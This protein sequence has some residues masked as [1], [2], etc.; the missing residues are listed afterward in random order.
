VSTHNPVL[1][2]LS[3]RQ[4][5]R[6]MCFGFVYLSVLFP[7]QTCLRYR[8]LMTCQFVGTTEWRT[9]TE[10]LSVSHLMNQEAG[11]KVFVVGQCECIR[12]ESSL[13]EREEKRGHL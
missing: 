12:L 7:S 10:S 3:E 1:Y 13:S 2:P 4:K 5:D 6:T 11:E 9:E 8:M